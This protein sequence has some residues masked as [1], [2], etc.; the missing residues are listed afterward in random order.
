[1]RL[2]VSDYY[3]ADEGCVFVCTET[4]YERT[5][6]AVKHERAIGKP[7]PL[8]DRKVPASWIKKGYVEERMMNNDRKENQCRPASGGAEVQ[9]G[10]GQADHA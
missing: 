4:G 8:F 6:E 2:L 3:V 7:I 9:A 5:P 10:E 1:M